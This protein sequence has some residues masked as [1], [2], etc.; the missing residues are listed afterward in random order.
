MTTSIQDR[1]DEFRSVITQVQKRHTSTKPGV[2]RQSLL[3]DAQKREANGAPNG[4]MAPGRTARSDFAR[5]AAEIGRGIT[6]TMA[7]LERLAH[8]TFTITLPAA[9]GDGRLACQ[10]AANVLH[11]R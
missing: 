10:D 2:H 7:K 4:G 8:C 6:G 5:K 1:T 3:T 11:R 9:S